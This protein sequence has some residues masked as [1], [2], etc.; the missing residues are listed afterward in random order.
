MGVHLRRF[1]PAGGDDGL[2]DGPGT[3]YVDAQPFQGLQQ[4]PPLDFGD[5]IGLQV[6]RDTGEL[7]QYRHHQPGYQSL[8]HMAEILVGLL[9]QVPQQAIV[10]L[11]LVQGGLQIQQN[12]IVLFVHAAH[13]GRSAENQRS[14]QAEVGE[15]QLPLFGVHRFLLTVL[16]LDG[17][18]AQAEPLHLGAEGL[19]CHQGHQRRPGLHNGMAQSPGKFVPI[20]GGPGKG[21]A[22]PAGG[23]DHRLAGVLPLLPCYAGKPVLFYRQADR[24]VLNNS[25]LCLPQGPQQGVDDIGGLV[26]LGEDPV[27]PLDLQRDPQPF[28]KS[29]CLLRGKTGDGAGEEFAVA[30]DVLQHLLHRTVVGHIAPALAGDVQLSAQLGIALQQGDRCPL[31]RSGQGRHTSGGAAADDDD[32]TQL[33]SSTFS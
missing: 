23:D 12:K 28:K 19:L 29:L 20:A 22:H 21:V 24:P 16:Y 4:L 15:K 33:F 2:P 13:M 10:Q 5:G 30:R 8:Q 9:A 14:G 17:H 31:L 32:L 7:Q 25:H 11:F 6:S 26:G 27:A 18:I 3:G 1:D